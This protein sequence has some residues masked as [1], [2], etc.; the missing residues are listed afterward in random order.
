MEPKLPKGTLDR[1]WSD[2]ANWRGPFYSCKSDPRHLVPKKIR[3]TGWTINFAHPLARTRLLAILLRMALI[4]PALLYLKESGHD[5]WMCALLAAV[6][7][8]SWWDSSRKSASTRYEES[9]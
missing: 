8:F 2:P 4:I 9:A 1:L 6:V 5:G 3:W 7:A